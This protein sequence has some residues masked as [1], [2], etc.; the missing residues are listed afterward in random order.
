MRLYYLQSEY[1]SGKH[2]PIAILSDIEPRDVESNMAP[3]NILI[4]D[5]G[6]L[7]VPLNKALI[8]DLQKTINKIDSSGRPKHYVDSL[9]SIME[10]SNW[11]EVIVR[12]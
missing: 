12:L 7:A 4:I 3:F 8:S 5:E 6:T 11:Q 9:G 2:R 10:T 1:E